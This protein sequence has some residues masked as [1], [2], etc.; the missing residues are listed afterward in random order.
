MPTARI[1]TVA[2]RTIQEKQA[3]ITVVSEAVERIM[4][5]DQK[6]IRVIIDEYPPENYALMGITFKDRREG[7][8]SDLAQDDIIMELFIK[9]GRTP[10][11]IDALSDAFMAELKKYPTFTQGDIR[12]IVT[13]MAAANFKIDFYAN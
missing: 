3:M 10:E 13:E 6:Y 1:T 9:A 5:R 11:E 2:G 12:I 4:D 8:N 7:G